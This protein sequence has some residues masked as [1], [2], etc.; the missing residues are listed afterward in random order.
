MI[1]AGQSSHSRHFLEQASAFTDAPRRAGEALDTG[2]YTEGLAQA[3]RLGL[4][5][6]RLRQAILRDALAAGADWW[7]VARLL[8]VHPQ[9]AFETCA[10]L[11]DTPAQQRPGCAVVLT[12]GLGAAHDVLRD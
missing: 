8:A 11:T 10:H 7:E 5:A 2:V 4:A 3:E 1:Q 9:Q 12:A 6:E